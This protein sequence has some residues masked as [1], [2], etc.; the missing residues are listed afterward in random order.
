MLMSVPLCTEYAQIQSVAN[1]IIALMNES[2][3]PPNRGDYGIQHYLTGELAWP[4]GLGWFLGK[5]GWYAGFLVTVLTMGSAPFWW[6]SSFPTSIPMWFV[7]LVAAVVIPLLHLLA[8]KWYLRGIKIR[9][10]LHDL[11]HLSRDHYCQ[12]SA[13]SLNYGYRDRDPEVKDFQNEA[14]HMRSY[15]SEFCSLLRSLFSMLLNEPNV[16]CAIRVGSVGKENQVQYQTI[17]RS[18]LEKGRET[19]SDPVAATEGIAKLFLSEEI[20]R[21]GVYFVYDID[22]AI[23]TGAMTN[24]RNQ[25]A[26]PKE[27]RK[28]SVIPINGWDGENEAMIGLLYLTSDN[29]SVLARQYID[30]MRFAGDLLGAVLSAKLARL[31]DPQKLMSSATVALKD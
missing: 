30:L 4:T 7:L 31:P 10:L 25:T 3:K 15:C 9:G 1:V 12:I 20:G 6:P 16:G 8:R 13:R 14:F 21:K 23:D 22:R 2:T 19:T 11:T 26:Y 24:S 29:D 18:G 28:M 17:A 27:I 5:N